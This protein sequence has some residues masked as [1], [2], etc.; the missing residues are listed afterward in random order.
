MIKIYTLNINHAD[1]EKDILN[2]ADISYQG[3]YIK[4][5][6]LPEDLN[7]NT[8]ELKSV[9][10][11]DKSF[12]RY[13]KLTLPRMKVDLLKEKHNIKVIRNKDDANYKIISKNTLYDLYD[14][15]WKNYIEVG[16]LI[17]KLKKA[18][19]NPLII[20]LFVNIPRG[21]YIN[22]IGSSYNINCNAHQL[23]YDFI[24]Y[25]NKNTYYFI[26]AKNET[27]YFD[28]INSTN[29]VLDTYMSNLCE[30]DALVIG[31]EEYRTM[32][33]MIKSED[34]DNQAIALEM[35]ANCN[36]EKSFD[37]ISLIYYFLQERLRYV[38]NWNNVNVK[39][40]KSRLSNFEA[41]NNKENGFYYSN[42]IQALI[43]EDKFTK[44][45]FEETAR[46][47]FYNIIKSKMHLDYEKNVFDL[48]VSCIKLK[49][50]YLEK[51]KEKL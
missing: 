46:Y 3:L 45:A 41:H 1:T 22:Y 38:K 11:K 13:P 5:K 47:A 39:A 2:Y 9:D 20:N 30:E 37:Y 29:L 44:F 18:N 14:Y 17:E 23:L 33:K 50:E 48:D 8:N 27:E 16:L 49:D 28:I 12:Y 15:S 4:D 40:L 24:N 42:Y 10:I 7:L 19:I 6:N 34:G 36:L 51:I 35:M 43:K 25:D 32:Q 26:P 21:S 31:L